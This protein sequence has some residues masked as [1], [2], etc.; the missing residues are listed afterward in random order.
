MKTGKSEVTKSFLKES[1]HSIAAYHLPRLIKCLNLL[2][3]KDIWWRP[4][5][6]SNSVGNLVLHLSGNVR[7]WIISGLGGEQDKRERDQEFAERG[8]ISRRA[9]IA[10]IRGTVAE[11]SS[12]LDC[13]S[14][15]SLLRMHDIQGYRVSGV[16]AVFQ[17]VH[18]FAYHTGQIIFV[19]KW[20]LGKD[21]RFTRLPAY[22]PKAAAQ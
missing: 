1:R 18:H 10:L 19:T 13:L 3:E 4:N 5:G 15:D 6:A 20:K 8:P 7:Q 22:K 12:V 11:A 9:L 16:Y 2:S 14:D 21:L 17:V